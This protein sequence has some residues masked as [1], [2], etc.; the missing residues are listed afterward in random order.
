MLKHPALRFLVKWAAT[1]GL[2]VLGVAF[3]DISTVFRAVETVPLQ[4]FGFSV[5]ISIVGTILV[6]A[7]LT[8]KALIKGQIR[9]SLGELV[10]I[11]F[12]MR[13]YILVLP[14]LA[15]MAIRWNRYRMRGGAH[16]AAALMA[17]ERVL[18]VVVYALCGVI[19]L[20]LD[21]LAREATGNSL[22]WLLII[23]AVSL[24]A[25]FVFVVRHD[26]EKHCEARQNRITSILSAR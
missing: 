26:R 2:L 20:A 5:F 25:L 16:N 10:Y 15:A 23:V 11:N 18:Q 6:P 24:V 17:F 21:P 13:F 14:R 8:K 9:A 7:F 4:A 1:I 19:L 22:T 3:V 12:S